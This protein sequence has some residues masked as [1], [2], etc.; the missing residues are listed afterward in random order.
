MKGEF[1]LL[2]HFIPRDL[3]DIAYSSTGADPAE[4]CRDRFH[5]TCYITTLAAPTQLPRSTATCPNLSH[6]GGHTR[7]FC[8]RNSCL[9]AQEH[10]LSLLFW[11]H[12]SNRRVR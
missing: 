9:S 7:F 12:S 3:V 5:I 10:R 11:T 4:S 2:V 1:I 6:T 8:F